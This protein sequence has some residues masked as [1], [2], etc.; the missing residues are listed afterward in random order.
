M[1]VLGL[2]PATDWESVGLHD[3]GVVQPRC[4]LGLLFELFE[5]LG[6]LPGL[7]GQNLDRH[8]AC[9]RLLSGLEDNAHAS[10]S[11]LANQVKV[12]QLFD[13]EGSQ[14]GRVPRRPRP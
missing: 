12:T 9:Q 13:L 4:N 10:P 2:E 8:L 1:R 3:V 11:D 5:L 14:R 6:I 7:T